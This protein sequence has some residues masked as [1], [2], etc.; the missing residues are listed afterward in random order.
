MHAGSY[1]S[2]PVSDMCAA[3]MTAAQ[4]QQAVP[5]NSRHTL[6]LGFFS[7]MYL[8]APVMVPPVPTPHTRTSTC[9]AATHSF[10]CSF[11]T[12]DDMCSLAALLIHPPRE[13]AL[14]CTF[15]L[16][17]VHIPNPSLFKST[18]GVHCTKCWY[19]W[20][21]SQCRRC[22]SVPG[23][24]VL[25]KTATVIPC[26]LWLPRSRGQWSHSEPWG[27][28][29]SQTAAKCTS[30]AWPLRSPLPSGQLPSCLQGLPSSGLSDDL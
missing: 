19:S 9:S 10:T 2:A 23:L 5:A 14:A 11:L 28:W 7:R 26:P 12:G 17:A 6:M 27:C 21:S 15:I 29:G 16:T 4:I 18:A 3:Y 22:I 25:R 13:Q 24:Y 1:R 30:L 20:P 8:P